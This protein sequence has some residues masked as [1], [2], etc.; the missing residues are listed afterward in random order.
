MDMVCPILEAIPV[1]FARE[2]PEECKN[3][4]QHF[5]EIVNESIGYNFC[6]IFNEMPLR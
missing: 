2:D 3:F 4:I 1:E 6:H 5:M